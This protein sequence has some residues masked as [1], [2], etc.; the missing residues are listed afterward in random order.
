MFLLLLLATIR[1]ESKQRKTI[2][3]VKNKNKNEGGKQNV[4]NDYFG[5]A[6]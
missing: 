1:S 3:S 4:R 5:T 6:K 2:E